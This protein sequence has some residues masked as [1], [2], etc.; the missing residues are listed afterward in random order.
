MAYQY[1]IMMILANYLVPVSFYLRL[2]IRCLFQT[3]EKFLDEASARGVDVLTSE[4][5]SGDP[6]QQVQNLKVRE[7]NV[8]PLAALNP[9]SVLYIEVLS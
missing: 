7:G 4:S 5:F 1:L 3:T 8:A 6:R 9:F 2:Y